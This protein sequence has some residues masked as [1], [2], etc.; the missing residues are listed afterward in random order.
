MLLKVHRYIGLSLAVFLIIIG[1]TG[2]ALV[3]FE[4]LD[5]AVNSDLWHVTPRGQSI[6]PVTLRER[7]QAAD[8]DNHY[9]YIEFPNRPDKAV[10]FYTEGS[11]DPR[12]GNVK[13]TTFD[14]AFA[15]QYS[16][17]KLGQRQWG[18][19]S[20]QREDLMTQIFFLHYALVLPEELGEP[21]VGY[22]ALI[23]AIN[24]VVGVI[25]TFPPF[26]RRAGIGR[27]FWRAWIK[28]WLIKT[29][30][31]GNRLVLDLHRA[32]G[33]WVW[34]LFLVVAISG[35]AFN[36]PDTYASVARKISGYSN[37]EADAPVLPK[38]LVDPPVSWHRA[39]ELGQT[40]M[41]Q[42]A[43]REGFKVLHPVALIYRRN[44]GHYFYR[45]MSDRDKGAHG[46]GT[47]AVGVNAQSGAFA[48]VEVPTGRNAG[49]T[50]TTWIKALHTGRVGGTPW[51]VVLA[52]LGVMLAMVSVTGVILWWRKKGGRKPRAVRRNIS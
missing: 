1:L 42:A 28:S 43:A 49:N 45:V 13:A 7:I 6:D 31:G 40:Y 19:F 4:P 39:Y 24:C 17:K 25:L 35:F 41:Q 16:G 20:L 21:L 27:S 37:I 26:R 15:D 52:L 36:L 2:T 32:I 50:F 34:I 47:T 8:P 9:Y 23:F 38:P 12:T 11:V 3:W 22:I 33:L 48:G 29:E 14:Q 30:G 44:T 51:K 18:N 5:E 10:A 46:S